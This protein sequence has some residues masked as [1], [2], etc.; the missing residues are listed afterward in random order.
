MKNAWMWSLRLQGLAQ[1]YYK[2][3]GHMYN[4]ERKKKLKI[5]ANIYAVFIVIRLA[6]KALGI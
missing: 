4:R 6:L 2:F 3:N 1:S 5:L